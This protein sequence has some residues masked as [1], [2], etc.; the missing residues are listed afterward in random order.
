L[1]HRV[2][3]NHVHFDP[4]T[5]FGDRTEELYAICHEVLDKKFANQ[6]KHDFASC[7][8]ELY[9]AATFIKRLG[10]RVTHPSDKGPDFYLHDLNCWA[11]VV[12]L[13]N[14]EKDN[15]NSISRP[16]TGIVT[17]Y[18]KDQI[19]LRIT[20][21][22]VYKARKILRYIREGTIKESQPVI[23]CINSG[24]LEALYRFPSYPVGGFP[25]VV[26]TLLPIGNMVVVVN[27][28]DMTV[29][30]KTFEYSSSVNKR[31]ADKSSEAIKT[32][33]FVDPEYAFISAVLYSYANVTDPIDSQHL[34]RDFFMIHNPLASH[35]L[36]VGSIKCG[37]E[38]EVLREGDF[39]TINTIE[40]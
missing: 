3:E 11:E 33:Y 24:W 22:F 35:P 7:Y 28:E 40:Y 39:I 37:I 12:T 23:I 38:Y 10:F 16:E 5:I 14:G 20:F 8:S 1:Y 27:R 18:P 36:P 31:K 26:T 19:M 32:D 9:F 6:I 25:E 2:Q 34:G 15:E 21:S 17:N 13:S 29:V 30:D 4:P